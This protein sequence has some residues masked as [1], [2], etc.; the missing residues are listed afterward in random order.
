MPSKD[1]LALGRIRSFRGRN[2][3]QVAFP[4]GGIGTG[5]V[6]IGGRGD[7]RDW[8]IFNHPGKGKLL[9][10]TFFAIWAQREEDRPV[11]KVLEGPIQPPYTGSHGFDRR[12]V[13]GLPRLRDAL[14]HGEYPFAWV[15]FDDP[16]LPVKVSMEAFNPFIPLNDRD[17]GIPVAIIRYHVE[18]ISDKPVRISIIG[19]LMN[20]IGY[21]GHG[22]IG[23]PGG[24]W[25]GGNLN[26]FRRDGRLVGLMMTSSKY[27]EDDP[28]FG[29]MALTSW[30]E[31]ET[32]H[33]PRWSRAGWFDELQQFWDDFTE[34]GRLEPL[35]EEPSPEGRTDVGSFG[36][37]KTLLPG[38]SAPLTFA[39]S[40]YFPVRVNEWNREE[41]V[42]GKPLRNFYATIFQDAWHVAKYTF[43]NLE[44]LES[45]TRK[46][47]RALF[48]STLPPYVLDAVSSQA[49]I[50][51]TNTCFRTDDGKFHA[52]EGCSEEVG[53]C[54]MNCTHVWNYEQALAYL[55]PQ[56]ERTM[57]ETDFLFNTDKEG[58]MAFRTLVPLGLARWGFKPAADGQMGCIMKL[59]REWQLSGDD[60]FLRKLWPAAK[61]ALEFAWKGWDADRDGMMEGEQHNTYDIEFYGPNPMMGTLY[62]GAL[63][64]GAKM[65]EAMGEKEKAK[66]YLNLF[67]KG[68]RKLDDLLWN[69]EYY[70]QKHEEVMT[71]KYQFGEGCLSDQMLGQWFAHVVGLGYLLPPERV[72][73]AISSV[74]RY[75][76]KEDLFNHSNCQRTYA[77]QDEKG[78]LLCSWPHGGRPPF[79][80][81]YS[82]E[83]WTGIEYQV[84]AH[85]IY[86][87]M[88]LEGLSI[89]KAVRD[90]YDGERRNPWNE[91]ECG[92][93][94][95][96]AMSSWSM[97]LALSGYTYSAP[98]KAI[99]FAPR[100]RPHNFR[101]IWTTGSG[102]GVFSQIGSPGEQLEEIRV[103]YGDLE[104]E[105]AGFA[106]AVGAPPSSVE[107][108]AIKGTEMIE[109][110]V[111]RFTSPRGE[112]ILLV[113]FASP[114]KLSDGESI[115]IKLRS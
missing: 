3:A 21:N 81:P 113:K 4:I 110:S 108:A 46:F 19:S 107:C 61:R 38:E 44:R 55:F 16:D 29:S 106:W 52:F 91:I 62:L 17:S 63:L 51:R 87:G 71:R 34:D 97:L 65:A 22:Q 45:E 79:P 10:M 54:P 114:V 111:E 89:V 92:D 80:F 7:L 50:I 88:L 66:E 69:G 96:R 86:E 64:A 74:Y 85:L 109:S 30:W 94:Y 48:E 8:E 31:D 2:S 36:L 112:E 13:P 6:S 68:R 103:L 41:A 75:N 15:H 57:R 76:F 11:T 78:L 27:P 99:C 105:M 101:S 60:E 5:T 47:H 23:G 77:L 26:S 9:P 82:D 83:V 37:L 33:T 93:H 102:W 56:L 90:R 95:A 43:E 49:S 42:R 59:Y 53:C 18:N 1:L 73:S 39:I 115:L 100:F 67:E 20:A 12:M 32:T 25:F 28:A 104:L 24:G 40:W 35:P 72:K 14:F 58:H 98:Q 70:V 84:A